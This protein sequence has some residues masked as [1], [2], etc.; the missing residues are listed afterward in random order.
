[1]KVSEYLNAW[2]SDREL[3]CQRSTWEALTVYVTKHLAPY[4]AQD[5]LSELTPIKCQQYARDKLKDGRTD[6]RSGLSLVSVRKHVSVLK[7]ALSEAV[8]LGLIPNNPA[9]YVR[10][11]RSKAHVT[12][13]TVFL[14][15]DEAQSLLRAFEGHPLYPAVVLALYYGLRRSEVLGLKWQAVDF[16]RNVLRIEHT[17]VKNLTTEAK[18][19]TKTENSR[20]SYQLLPEVREM[21]LELKKTPSEDVYVLHRADGSPLRPDSLTRGFQRVLRRQGLP[22]MRFHDLRHSTASILFDRGWQIEDVKNWLGHADIETTSNIYVHYGRARKVLLAHDL[23]GM[24]IK[25]KKL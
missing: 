12:A 4:F 15:S 5:E 6:G 2:L 25:P 3:Y 16:T 10:L 14:T 11:P 1:M 21:L 22:S 13:R 17:V 9:Q 24:L 18:D 23:E 7:Q 20:R 19:S 8:T